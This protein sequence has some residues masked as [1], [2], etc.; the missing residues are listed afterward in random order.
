MVLVPAWQATTCPA[1]EPGAAVLVADDDT[2]FRD[3]LL[4][5]LNRTGIA[6]EGFADGHTLVRSFA[7]SRSTCSRIRAVVTDLHMPGLSGLEVL[8]RLRAT[9]PRLPVVLMSS[10]MTP[11]IRFQAV[12]LGVSALV[13]KPFLLPQFRETLCALV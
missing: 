7:A 6:A 2:G 11:D 10:F 3:L 9:D 1:T 12:R 4:E 8:A 5:F 13:S